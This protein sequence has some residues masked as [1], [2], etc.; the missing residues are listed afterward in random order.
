MIEPPSTSDGTR[1][2]THA[3]DG[4]PVVSW[5]VLSE[6]APQKSRDSR[7]KTRL[8]LVLAH[9]TG[10]CAGVWRPVRALLDDHDSTALDFRGHGRSSSNRTVRSWWEMALD[11]LA[12]APHAGPEAPIGVGHSMG[13]ASLI[14]AELLE[15]GTFAGLVLIE[16]IVFPGPYR[17]DPHHP[18]VSLALRRRERFDS[19]VAVQDSYGAKPP[20]ASWHPDALAG[21]VEGGFVEDDGGVRLACP[22]R[23]EAEVFTAASAHAAWERLDEVNVPTAVLYGEETDTYQPGHGEALAARMAQ[24]TA[25]GIPGTGHFLPMER[26]D[27][28]AHTV[29]EIERRLS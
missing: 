7:G 22:P 10:F 17:R 14:M 11:V 26:P 25:R 4:F 6:P 3:A 20:F 29:R 27:V 12:V 18:L 28:V 15:P 2:V 24:A 23:S 13:G 5:R 1:L 21:Y 16:P 9:A 8:P 19:P